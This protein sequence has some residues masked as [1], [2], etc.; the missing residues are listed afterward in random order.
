MVKILSLAANPR[1]TPTLALLV[2]A[3]AITATLNQAKYGNHFEF[4]TELAVRVDQMQELLL[5]HRPH[6]VHLIGHGTGEGE[7]ILD[8][9]AGELHAVIRDALAETF[10]LQRGDVRCVVINACYSQPQADAIARHVAGVVYTA[11]ARGS[12]VRWS[13][14]VLRGGSWNNNVDNAAASFR[15]RNN[16]NNRNDNY[17]FRV[18]AVSASTFFHPFSGGVARPL[19]VAGPPQPARFRQC[20]LT[21]NKWS[22]DRGEGEEKRRAGLVCPQQGGTGAPLAS[23]AY[24]SMGRVGALPP[25][26]RLSLRRAAALKQSLSCAG[27][28]FVGP[29]SSQ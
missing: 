15:N 17:G 13:G 14:L 11:S 22:A 25:Q 9:A 12:R 5:Q 26:P 10:R 2:E 21:S 7:I 27:D 4:V 28:C 18:V 16:P 19:P 23:G 8:S 1:N 24:K 20:R 6:V 29:P 3:D